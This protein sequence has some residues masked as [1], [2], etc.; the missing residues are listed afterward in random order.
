MQFG[1]D[2]HEHL[3]RRHQQRP[4]THH[5][6]RRHLVIRGGAQTAE[7]A[8]QQL[9]DRIAQHDGCHGQLKIQRVGEHFLEPRLRPTPGNQR[10]TVHVKAQQNPVRNQQEQRLGDLA[11]GQCF[12]PERRDEKDHAGEEQHVAGHHQNIADT[13]LLA[14]IQRRL[15]DTGDTAQPHRQHS[16]R[17]NRFRLNHRRCRNHQVQY[18]EQ[19][20]VQREQRQ[21][22]SQ[23]DRCRRGLHDLGSRCIVLPRAVTGHE[24][25][26]PAGQPQIAQSRYRGAR[27]Q[28]RPQP[29][30]FGTQLFQQ[31]TVDKKQQHARYQYLKY[32]QTCIAQ[33]TTRGDA[34][35]W[36]R[37]KGGHQAVTGVADERSWLLRPA[38]PLSLS[39]WMK[40]A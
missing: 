32:R 22:H 14:A 7:A 15:E 16:P 39:R 3:V 10:E 34:H 24:F 21:A 18:P 6:L 29:Q 12:Q 8:H 35:E 9:G 25:H 40:S 37:V 31:M 2:R 17:Q 36:A 26:Y 1:H 23:R 28:H 19:H 13:G 20:G 27:Q 5:Q 4:G 30:L 38:W 11:V 33:Q